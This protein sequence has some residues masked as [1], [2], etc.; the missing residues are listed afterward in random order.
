M[1][2]D[3][4]LSDSLDDKLDNNIVITINFWSFYHEVT[5]STDFPTNAFLPHRPDDAVFYAWQS[6]CLDTGRA[7]DS[8]RSSHDNQP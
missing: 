8:H 6:H 3:Y 5:P 7:L 4:T 2:N 1:M